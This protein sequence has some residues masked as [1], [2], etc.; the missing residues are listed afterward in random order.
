[1]TAKQVLAVR[2][3]LN[4]SQEKFGRLVNVSSRTVANWE[5]RGTK[6]EKHD[7]LIRAAAK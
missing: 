7:K 4:L 3:K 1:M 6:F 5:E 2:K